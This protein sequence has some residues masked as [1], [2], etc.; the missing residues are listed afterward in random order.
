MH[1]DPG[2]APRT[3]ACRAARRRQAQLWAVVIVLL[4][5]AFSALAF[6][7]V[8]KEL[9]GMGLFRPPAGRS[10]LEFGELLRLVKLAA[11]MGVAVTFGQ[12]A[13]LRQL[14]GARRAGEKVRA[15][16]GLCPR[17]A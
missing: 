4:V 9:A 2:P 13:L 8:P 7:L 16:M 12:D 17:Q 1:D 14:V 10:G 6:S 15:W 5:A 11:A 3:P